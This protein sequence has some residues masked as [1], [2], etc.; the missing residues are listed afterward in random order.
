MEQTAEG[1]Q[2]LMASALQM[3]ANK[4]RSEAELRK[5][6]SQKYVA[7]AETMEQ[8]IIR[9]KEMSLIDDPRFA[10]SYARSRLSLK[11]LGRRRLA[12][13]LKSKRVPTQAIEQALDSAFEERTENELIDRAIAKHAR[14]H[15]EPKDR[16]TLKKLH[17]YLVRLGF[18]F[19]LVRSKLS[20][21]SK[22]QH[23]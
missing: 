9:L 7:S 2:Q 13:E 5:R 20:L 10:E 21:Q 3:L 23:D 12:H 18:D 6:L 15:G 16:A 11:P 17:D 14:L 8:C 22:R 4:P 19:D 1:K